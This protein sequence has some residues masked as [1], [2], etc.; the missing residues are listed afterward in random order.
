MWTRNCEQW[1][2]MI[3]TFDLSNFDGPMANCLIIVVSLETFLQRFKRP[4]VSGVSQRPTLVPP[5]WRSRL[6]GAPVRCSFQYG[7]MLQIYAPE[8]DHRT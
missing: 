5:S 6:G 7:I 8:N 1:Q 4:A 3:R 2:T